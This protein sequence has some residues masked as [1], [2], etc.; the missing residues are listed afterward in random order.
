MKLQK[1]A[2]LTS[3]SNF[4]K[5]VGVEKRDTKAIRQSIDTKLGFKADPNDKVNIINSVD[6][7]KKFFKVKSDP[8]ST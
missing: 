1:K 3:I 4:Q 5:Q 8:E 2:L 7:K 6:K